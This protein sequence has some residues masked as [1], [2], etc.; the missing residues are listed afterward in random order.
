MADETPEAHATRLEN[1]L[2]AANALLTRLGSGRVDAYRTPKLP[3][4]I[5]ADPNMWFTQVD[6][7]FR[8][9]NITVEGT[10]ADFVIQ[11]L[12]REAMAVIID[13]AALEPQPTDI[14]TQIKRRLIASFA[15]STES[16]LRQLLKGQVLNDGKPSL[17]L[18]RLRHLDEGS[19]CD[20]AIL[21]SIFLDQLHSNHR[22]ILIA[23][24]IEDLNQ[25]AILADKIVENTP[26]EARLAAV[27]NEVDSPNI[28]SE[29]K[30]LADLFSTV[31]VRIDKL[32][33]SVQASKAQ[34]NYNSNKGGNRGRS[35]GRSKSRDP[36]ELCLAHRKYPNNPT[37]CRKWCSEY[38]KWSSKN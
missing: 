30:L 28:S 13:I 31:T 2:S 23:S 12:D 24:G 16:K 35:R 26:S 3:P 27:T 34:S 19:R 10:K 37:S 29:L 17:T 21:K 5:R 7:S 6:A 8:H 33:S 11:S 18:S 38:S 36:S 20:E 15:S 9:S 1:E 22:A 25:L 4:F 14:Y 32:E